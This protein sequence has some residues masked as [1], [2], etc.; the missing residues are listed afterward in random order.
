[1][2]YS[3]AAIRRSLAYVSLGQGYLRE[4]VG[5][6]FRMV[7]HISSMLELFQGTGNCPQSLLYLLQNE[8]RRFIAG[9]RE[10]R[11]SVRRINEAMAR[12]GPEGEDYEEEQGEEDEEDS[13]RENGGR[14]GG[15]D[16]FA[17]AL[18]WWTIDVLYPDSD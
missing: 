3:T 10:V 13:V 18:G 6:R 1:M 11:A 9:Y 15:G 2:S 4:Q 12:W 5:H 17:Q 8:K 14:G 7:N 16:I